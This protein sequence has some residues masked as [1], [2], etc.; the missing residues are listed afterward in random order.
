MLERPVA[1]VFESVVI[2]AFFSSVFE[3]VSANYFMFVPTANTESGAPNAIGVP[4]KYISASFSL[5]L[6]HK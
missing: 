1:N 2:F 3:T 6:S 5:S 4:P